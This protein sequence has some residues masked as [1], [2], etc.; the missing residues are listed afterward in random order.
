[1]TPTVLWVVGEPG[2]GKTT[3]VS[4]LIDNKRTLHPKPKWTIGPRTAAVGHYTGGKFDGADTVPYNG[5][6]QALVFWRECLQ[7]RSLTIFDGD[8]FSNAGVVDWFR[9][10]KKEP[11]LL[12]CIHFV[13]PPEEGLRRRQQRGTT[14]NPVW[15]KGRITKAARFA[16]TA[17]THDVLELDAREPPSSLLARAKDFLQIDWELLEEDPD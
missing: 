16:A 10:L 5:V 4:R 12:R 9:D 3:L 8:R 14:Q 6:E 11:T 13:I 15:V 2:A 7:D 17:F 1:M